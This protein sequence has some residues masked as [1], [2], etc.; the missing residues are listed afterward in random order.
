M[1]KSGSAPRPLHPPRPLSNS[2][3]APHAQDLTIRRTTRIPGYLAH[4]R[5][6][7]RL[8]YGPISEPGTACWGPAAAH[9]PAEQS[10]HPGGSLAYHAFIRAP[11]HDQVKAPLPD[12]R[13]IPATGGRWPTSSFQYQGRQ[14]QSITGQKLSSQRQTPVSSYPQ[15]LSM[16]ISDT[17]LHTRA[18]ETTASTSSFLNLSQSD[19]TLPTSNTQTPPP[20]VKSHKSFSL[21][22][23]HSHHLRRSWFNNEDPGNL[24]TFWT[25]LSIFGLV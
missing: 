11:Y 10:P 23:V 21:P 4:P 12:Q 8:R 19:R 25:C 24:E 18:S 16:Q 7:S 17:A 1:D 9:G 3:P 6:P 13:A 20:A 2:P 15:S 5:N 14:M 22:T